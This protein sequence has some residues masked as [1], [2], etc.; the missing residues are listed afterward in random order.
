MVDAAIAG[1]GEQV[2]DFKGPQSHA[3]G[4]ITI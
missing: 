4:E 2:V 3:A 1:A